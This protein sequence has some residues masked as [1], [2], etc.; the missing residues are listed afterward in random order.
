MDNA[1]PRPKLREQLRRCMRLH[2]ESGLDDSE[3]RARHRW[4]IEILIYVC[5]CLIVVKAFVVVWAIN[6]FNIPIHP[7]VVIGPTVAFAFL[8]TSLYYWLRD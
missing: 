6:H 1:N 5:W 2:D 4:R 3:R 7:L 8:A